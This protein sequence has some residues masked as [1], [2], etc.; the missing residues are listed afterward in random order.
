MKK[1]GAAVSSKLAIAQSIEATNVAN[2]SALTEQQ[3][4]RK[5]QKSRNRNHHYHQVFP[6]ML[7]LSPNH[8]P[9]RNIFS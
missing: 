7:V 4:S 9:I 6:K 1:R 8:Q 3:N 2:A 5:K